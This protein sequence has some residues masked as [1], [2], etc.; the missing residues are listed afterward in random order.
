M[1][2]GSSKGTNTGTGTSTCTATSTVTGTSTHLSRGSLQL[3][4][5]SRPPSVEQSE[6][7]TRRRL[8]HMTATHPLIDPEQS[9]CQLCGLFEHK[10]H[11][12][13]CMH[14]MRL[15]GKG[16]WR[17][18]CCKW[19]CCN[20]SRFDHSTTSESLRGRSYLGPQPAA[21]PVVLLLPLHSLQ[22]ETGRSSQTEYK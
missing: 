4:A 7:H 9:H 6:L 15:Q 11:S 8:S 21:A 18:K 13:A 10:F 16:K 2:T 20:S 17:W 14:E 1:N 22:D 19:K 5:W 12:S 3:P